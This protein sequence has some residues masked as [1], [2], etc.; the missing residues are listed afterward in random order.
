MGFIDT[1][2]DPKVPIFYNVVH[3]VGVY[4]PNHRDDV[5]LIQYLLIAFYDRALASSSIYTRPKGDLTVDGSCGPITNNWILKFQLDV[6][7]RY[8]NTVAV[9]NRVDRVRNKNLV[10][11]ISGTVYTDAVLNRFVSA[12][13]PEAFILLPSL[14]PL[15]DPNNVGP[16]TADMA[17]PPR[18]IVPEEIGGF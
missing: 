17:G 11:S 13:N 15:E 3:A 8:P 1:S 2:S 12:I 14:V 6:N 10:G 16:P 9:D 4:C 18:E 7:K 5:K